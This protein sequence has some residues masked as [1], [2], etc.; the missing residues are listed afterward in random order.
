L[1]CVVVRPAE[2]QAYIFAATNAEE[3]RYLVVG[4]PNRDVGSTGP[5]DQNPVGVLVRVDGHGCVPIGAPGDVMMHPEGDLTEAVV[6]GLLND[7]VARYSR[8]YG[9]RAKFIAALKAQHLYPAEPW[10][11]TLRDAI[12]RSTLP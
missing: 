11:A 8:A 6:T 10:I 5:W 1:N 12:E 4:G 3:G 7:V 9:S 2:Q